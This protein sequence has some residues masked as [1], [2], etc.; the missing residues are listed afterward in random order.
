MTQSLVAWSESQ[1]SATLVNMAAVADAHV[2]VV[3]DDVVVPSFAPLLGAEYLVGVSATQAQIASPSLRRTINLDLAPIDRTAE[4][5]VPTPFLPH[6]DHPIPL[7][8]EEALNF[9]V[10]EDGVGAARST[11]LAWLVDAPVVPDTRP[12]FTVRTTA[13]VTL[14]TFTWTNGALTFSQTL[15]KGSYDIVGA[16]AEAAG[17]LAFRFVL[18]GASHRPGGI[19]YDAALDLEHQGQRHGK[20]GIWGSFAHNTP[21][22]VDFLSVS[23]DTAETVWLDLVKTA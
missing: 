13:A 15:P 18:V 16:R 19:G 14:T 12:D 11:G 21:P 17:L 4:P 20:W 22:T 23:A 9:L 10:A 5:A 2:R 6:F 1:D 3:G 7:D 8:A